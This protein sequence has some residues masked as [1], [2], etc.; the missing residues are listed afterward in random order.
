MCKQVVWTKSAKKVLD[1][2][3]RNEYRRI[4]QA[5]VEML[6]GDMR[7]VAKL[8]NKPTSRLRVGSWRVIF[9]DEGDSIKIT[10]VVPRGGAYKR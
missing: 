10:E 4:M 8:V 1:G 6:N 5:V 7:K 9:K 2:L 3:P